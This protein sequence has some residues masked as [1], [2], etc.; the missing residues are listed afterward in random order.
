MPQLIGVQHW[1]AGI[2][3]Y[4]ERDHGAGPYYFRA[5]TKKFFGYWSGGLDPRRASPLVACERGV[6]WHCRA[7]A[8]RRG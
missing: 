4:L 7:G 2:A 1:V 8:E 6:A 3:R 5:F